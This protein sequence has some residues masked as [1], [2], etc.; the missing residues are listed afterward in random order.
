MFQARVVFA[1]ALHSTVQHRS[2]LYLVQHPL[3]TYRQAQHIQGDVIILCLW[4]RFT[5]G[6]LS[7]KYPND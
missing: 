5:Q 1:A 3:Y 2:P 7:F 4:A 6:R